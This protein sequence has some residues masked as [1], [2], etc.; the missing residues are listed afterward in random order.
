[1][2]RAK[3]IRIKGRVQGVGFRP[4]VYAL[5]IEFYLKGN[6]QNNMDGV[7]ILVEGEVVAIDAFISALSVRKPRLA[8][9]DKIEVTDTNVEGHQDFEIIPSSQDGKSELIIPIDTSICQ[10]CLQDLSDPNDRRYRYPFTNC[11]DCGPRYTI[12]EGLPY[13]RPQTTMRHFEMCIACQQEYENP[14]NRR[15]HAQPN[16]CPTCG[17]RY[18][19]YQDGKEADEEAILQKTASFIEDGKIVAL[20]GIGGYHLV[21]DAMN[22]QAV[23]RLRD[24]KRRQHKPLAVMARSLSAVEK[25]CA[26]TAY[27]REILTGVEAPIVLCKKREQALLPENIAP[28]INTIGMMLPYAPVHAVLFSYTALDFLVMTSANPSKLPML[29]QDDAAFSYLQGLA[30]VIVMHNREIVH[31][32]D[33]S[34][35]QIFMDGRQQLIRRARG[36]APEP[37]P[38]QENVD[39]IMALGSQQK[40]TFALGRNHQAF[41]GPHIGDLDGLEMLAYEEQELHHLIQWFGIEPKL[42][43]IDKH[44]LFSTREIAK[45]FHLPILEVQ[46]HHAHMVSCMAEHNALGENSFG[47]ILDGTGFGEDGNIWG[48]EILY[49]SEKS[50]ERK[51]HLSYSP[52]PGGEKSILDPW[53]NTIGMLISM[54]GEKQGTEMCN[55]LFPDRMQEI[56]VLKTMVSR[57]INSPLA[58]TC[59]RLFDTV[60]AML[61]LCLNQDYDGEAAILLSEKAD[62]ELLNKVEPY[63]Y[64]ISNVSGC[65]CISFKNM[66]KEIYQDIQLHKEIKVI[67]SRFHQT[68]ISAI[69]DIMKQ[70]KKEKTERK[71]FCSGGSFHNEFLAIGLEKNLSKLGFQ[72]FLQKE[73]PTNDGGLSFGQLMIGQNHLKEE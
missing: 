41:I 38:T 73:I 43:V 67:S 36:Y 69:C 59:G 66:L 29:Y 50:F 72:V 48:F 2:F 71:I 6:V 8:K 21:C 25:A 31:P 54:F 70:V 34:V 35:V 65:Y 39:G 13:D 26:I 14:L 7:K 44:P 9:I 53:K 57:G 28:N 1:M 58:G 45:R 16:A 49:G 4:F 12:I 3:I 19:L 15:H 30:D 61:G 23:Q 37:Y 64:E 68:V 62:I 10:K 47:I 27:E 46:H 20:K 33:D 11:T 42:I 55:R 40:N 52:L 51:G 32:I 63:S 17:P 18:V 56:Q 60:A 22:E 5:A 24:R